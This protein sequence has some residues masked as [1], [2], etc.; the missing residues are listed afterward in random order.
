METIRLNLYTPLDEN[1]TIINDGKTTGHM[2]LTIRGRTYSYDDGKVKNNYKGILSTMSPREWHFDSE[3]KDYCI[4]YIN[5]PAFPYEVDQV[6]NYF[7]LA[8]TTEASNNNPRVSSKKYTENNDAPSLALPGESF[9]DYSPEVSNC[10]AFANSVLLFLSCHLLDVGVTS[11]DSSTY[12]GAFATTIKDQNKSILHRL[13]PFQYCFT[14][15]ISL[16]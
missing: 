3:K 10:R 8:W 9:A 11:Y 16:L 12:T 4:Y 13:N 14:N 5:I 7:S 15:H 6:L 1:G 2:D